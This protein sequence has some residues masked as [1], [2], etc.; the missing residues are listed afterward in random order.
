[1]KICASTSEE[2]G[3]IQSRIEK[4]E[5]DFIS[6][7]DTADIPFGLGDVTLTASYLREGKLKLP[8]DFTICTVNFTPYSEF[9]K[10]NDKVID[11]MTRYRLEL[12]CKFDNHYY[13]L[14]FSRLYSPNVSIE[15][16]Y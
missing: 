11:E 8:R 2:F 12:E 4:F 14:V 10:T 3:K 5:K 15:I 6:L 1:M 7:F 13:K 16:P 9:E